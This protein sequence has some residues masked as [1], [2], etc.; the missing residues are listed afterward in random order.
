MENSPMR[1]VRLLPAAFAL[2]F[3]ACRAL[4]EPW[5][6]HFQVGAHP[7]V[8]VEADDGRV[9]IITWDRPEVSVHV[10]SRGWRI[11]SQLR[12]E[13]EQ[14][15]SDVNISAR[16]PQGIRFDFSTKELRIQVS[17]P[18]EADLDVHTGDGPVAVSALTGRV[19][20]RTGDGSISLRGVHGDI[21]LNTGDGSIDGEGLDGAL[22]ASTRDGRVRVSGRFDAL[23]IGSGDGRV[24]AEAE[25]GSVVR[26][27]WSLHSR[28]GS[29]SLRVPPGLKADLEA[30]T[31]DGSIRLDL[32]VEVTG[33]RGRS[34]LQG[35]INGGGPPLRL[36]SGDGSIRVEQITLSARVR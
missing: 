32:P 8:T 33:E 15:G 2:V 23:E 9:E 19:D 3:L 14:H 10:E 27:G 35:R 18:R 16:T 28:D 26:E 34:H 24:I 31:G 22:N 11:G 12:L 5:D 6:R 29:L 25:P 1:L 7:H 30:Q 4:A 17:M 21:R 13:A 36:H 20:V